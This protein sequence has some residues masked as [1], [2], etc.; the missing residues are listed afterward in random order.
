MLCLGRG[1]Y[2]I[3]HLPSDGTAR[4]ISTR[5]SIST[6]SCPR[7]QLIITPFF[8][9]TPHI[10]ANSATSQAGSSSESDYIG[11]EGHDPVAPDVYG[12]EVKQYKVQSGLYTLWANRTGGWQRIATMLQPVRMFEGCA[13]LRYYN[14]GGVV[15]AK[16]RCDGVC[17]A[18][19]L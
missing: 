18:A 11:G 6:R 10:A 1:C 14:W 2:T 9:Y 3:A 19:L 16:L 13:L 12:V 17:I 15:D 5:L 4:F 8:S 7:H